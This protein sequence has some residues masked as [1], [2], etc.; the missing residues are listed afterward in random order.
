MPGDNQGQ[1]HAD[2]AANATAH[3]GP[4]ACARGAGAGAV[5]SN[6][7]P[8]NYR[9]G[10]TTRILRPGIDSLYVSHPGDLDPDADTRLSELKRLAQAFEDALSATATI[11]LADR[12]FQV[13]PG[14]SKFYRYLL[15]GDNYFI[16]VSSPTAKSLPLA[17][18]Q[19]RSRHLLDVGPEAAL[20][21]L[22]EIVAELGVLSG[23]AT[24]SRADLCVDFR[25]DFEL[26][27]WSSRAWITRARKLAAYTVSGKPTGWTISEG[28]DLSAR[29][30]DKTLEIESSG[31]DYW[32]PIWHQA[33][34]QPPQKVYRL[35]F[36]F[37][38]RVLREHGVRTLAELLEKLGPL[39]R[40]ASER[41]LRLSIPDESQAN[42]SRWPTH[43]VWSALSAV[44]WPGSLEGVSLPDRTPGDFDEQ[45]LF[46]Q[47]L[48]GLS[49]FMALSGI[50]DSL[51]AMQAW[52]WAAKDYHDGRSFVSERTFDEYL[53][54]KAAAKATRFNK[55]YEESVE[56]AVLRAEQA[57]QTTKAQAWKRAKK[58][59]GY[60]D[61]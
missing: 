34:W 60:G 26:D 54:E 47:A 9:E 53:Y 57:I 2:E 45:R 52:Y 20:V 14:G 50:T 31:K 56:R 39:W 32:K 36:Q 46:V 30:Y 48:G 51:E 19:V 22:D 49:T 21:E 35:E 7:A 11:I 37:R 29:L 1:S 27:A 61:L 25:A 12:H 4:Q 3:T 17:H 13:R 24:I 18:T 6:T 38:S 41:W 59:R 5:P 10:E 42:Q 15:A 55:P 43:P 8:A 33:G 40:Y 23:P 58:V 16:Q 44:E 28:N